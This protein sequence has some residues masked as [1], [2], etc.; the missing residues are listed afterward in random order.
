MPPLPPGVRPPPT[1]P[2]N[3]PRTRT[4][5]PSTDLNPS[6]SESHVSCRS[7]VSIPVKLQQLQLSIDDVFDSSGNSAAASGAG[8]GRI[9]LRPLTSGDGLLPLLF[10]T[11]CHQPHH[12]VGSFTRVLCVSA[13]VAW[14]HDDRVPQSHAGSLQ[15]PSCSFN[16]S[17]S[18]K[19]SL[20]VPPPPDDVSLF[21]SSGGQHAEGRVYVAAFEM[22]AAVEGEGVQQLCAVPPLASGLSSAACLHPCAELDV[23]LLWLP[24]PTVTLASAARA[25]SK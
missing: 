5:S 10:T 18:F 4:H 8:G 15:L 9:P 16:V 21:L 23:P 7:S 24:R 2:P 11:S 6:C 13:Q 12:P 20:P 1:H 17:Q 25:A 19:I 3:Y 22:Q 14:G